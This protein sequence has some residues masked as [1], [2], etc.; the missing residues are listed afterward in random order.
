MAGKIRIGISGWTYGGWRGVFYPP[1]LPHKQELPYAAR[2]FNTIEINGTHYGLQRPENFQ[3]WRAETPED[4]VFAVKGSR[5]ITHM[6]KLR[7]VKTAIANFLA[8]GVLALGPKLGPLLWQFPPRMK[9][10]P[11][12]FEDFLALLPTDTAQ[13]QKLAR[14]H[15]ARMKGRAWLKI[16]ANAPMRHAVEIRHDSFITDE[17]VALLRR[18]NTALVVADSVAWPRKMDL[19]ADF[20]YCR[21]HGSEQL[22]V[23]GYE[24][25]ALDNWAKLVRGWS[26]GK[27]PKQAE[28]IS[29]PV[30]PRA[31]GRD[32]Y[33]YFDNDAKVRAPADAKELVR[34]LMSKSRTK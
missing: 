33:V 34:I 19:T 31:G 17:F 9:F 23:S 14:Q 7:N 27:D 26:Q 22:Y 25:E 18:Y 29:K 6:L 5:Y 8:S 3:R 12:V 32:V 13:A 11:E 21:L 16:D 2:Q 20:V 1:K 24:D 30:K 10:N 28:R 4:F 15:D